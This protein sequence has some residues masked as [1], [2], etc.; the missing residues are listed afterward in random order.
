MLD[1]PRGS[2][3]GRS[4]LRPLSRSIVF[5]RASLKLV[6]HTLPP[7]T[8]TSL[9]RRPTGKLF[10]APGAAVAVVA[11]RPLVVWPPS[12]PPPDS[13]TAAAAPARTRTVTASATGRPR[14]RPRVTGVSA[15]APLGAAAVGACGGAASARIGET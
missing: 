4:P 12:S 9:G 7:A 11:E 1:Q 15:A 8:V 13:A 14:R 2:A 3:S 5:R 10:T 6:T